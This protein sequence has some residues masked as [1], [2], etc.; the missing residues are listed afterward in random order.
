MFRSDVFRITQVCYRSGDLANLI[1]GAGG[2]TKL[3]HRLFARQHIFTPNFK[4]PHCKVR[5][6]PL[7]ENPLI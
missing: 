2:Q 4:K 3:S 6:S 1:V 7:Q 5:P